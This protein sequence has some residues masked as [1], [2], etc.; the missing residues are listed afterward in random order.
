MQSPK[1]QHLQ[2]KNIK[3]TEPVAEKVLDDCKVFCNNL[4][5]NT[6][7]EDLTLHL[8]S[9]GE[10]VGS[11]ILKRNG[12]SLGCGYVEF[13]DPACVPI[14]IEQLNGQ[15]LQGRALVIREYYQ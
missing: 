10:V 8:S 6:T 7:A 4:S 14:A 1:L 3:S 12:R 2:K 11:E 5:W 9:C 13:A 15:E